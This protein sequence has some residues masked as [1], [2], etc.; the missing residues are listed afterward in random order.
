M[1]GVYLSAVMP[2]AR[3]ERVSCEAGSTV[4]EE[5][6]ARISSLAELFSP[7][8]LVV[9]RVR[10]RA[11]CRTQDRVETYGAWYRSTTFIMSSTTKGT[12]KHYDPI[13]A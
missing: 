7:V 3:L 13:R 9:F 6:C 2:I 8:Y 4:L 11:L 10:I 12:A 1:R 5:Q